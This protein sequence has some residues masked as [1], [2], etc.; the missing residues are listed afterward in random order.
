MEAKPVIGVTT[1]SGFTKT[2]LL[3]DVAEQ[4]Y[5]LVTVTLKLPGVA[6]LID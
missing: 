3:V 5:P 1:G 6:V 4:P 2:G